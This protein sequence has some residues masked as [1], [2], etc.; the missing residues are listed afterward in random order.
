M[1]DDLRQDSQVLIQSSGKCSYSQLSPG[2]GTSPGLIVEYL[3]TLTWTETEQH[4]YK[5]NGESRVCW[6]R[7]QKSPVATFT[8][9]L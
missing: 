1:S 3:D 8:I 4:K 5:I 2:A 6:G 9:M 7:V